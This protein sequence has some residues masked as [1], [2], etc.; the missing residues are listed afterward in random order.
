MQQ[1]RSSFSAQPFHFYLDPSDG[2]RNIEELA[3]ALGR[4]SLSIGVSPRD[5]CRLPVGQGGGG[6]VT[7]L[8][9]LWLL[10]RSRI[11]TCWLRCFATVNGHL[12]LLPTCLLPFQLVCPEPSN[13]NLRCILA[14]TLRDVHCML[15]QE[16][17]LITCVPCNPLPWRGKRRRAF[18]ICNLCAASNIHSCQQHPQLNPNGVCR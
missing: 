18:I 10:Y 1:R 11:P 13:C 2:S 17:P 14:C 6:H 16:K 15:A 8:A 7:A 3:R 5:L 4:P 12:P 9:T